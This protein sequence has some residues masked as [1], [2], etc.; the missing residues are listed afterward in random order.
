MVLVCAL[1]LT[2][3]FGFFGYFDE[4]FFDDMRTAIDTCRAN[5][6]EEEFFL[7]YDYESKD[8]MNNI[9]TCI[10][11]S[12]LTLIM[13]V[14]YYLFKPDPFEM[15]VFMRR[16]GNIL[17][18]K[19]IITYHTLII[20]HSLTHSLTHSLSLHGF[21]DHRSNIFIDDLYSKFF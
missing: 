13:A 16:N 4:E 1:I 3:P 18:C 14:L 19:D 20:S 2:I 6:S 8:I 5:Y 12:L 15:E 10:M 17:L 11:S 7:T 21:L 9:V